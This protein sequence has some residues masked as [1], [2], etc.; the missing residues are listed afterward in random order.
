MNNIFNIDIITHIKGL[1]FEEAFSSAQW[2]E[3]EEHL[4]VR[5][6]SLQSLIMAKRASARNK[7]LDDL[8]HLSE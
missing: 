3:I 6:L 5:G 1:D 4:S 7:D 8:E 2:F